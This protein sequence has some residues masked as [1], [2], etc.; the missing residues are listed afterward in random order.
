MDAISFV[1][2]VQTQQLR[3]AKLQDLVHL[4]EDEKGEETKRS[5]FVEIV[6]IDEEEH[7]STERYADR[8]NE[9]RFRRSIRADGTGSYSLN[10]KTVN[11]KRYQQI[12]K[13]IGI[14]VKARNFL[15]FQGDV[16]TI[17]Q[18]SPEELTK[19]FEEI[20][21]SNTLSE[22]YL[23]AEEACETVLNAGDD[24]MRTFTMKKSVNKEK[25][26]VQE[27][28]QEAERFQEMLDR[29]RES[30]SEFF[31]WQLFQ[32]QKEIEENKEKKGKVEADL[33]DVKEEWEGAQKAIKDHSKESATMRRKILGLEKSITKRK[34]ELDKAKPTRIKYSAQASGLKEGAKKAEKELRELERKGKAQDSK[35]T[36][37]KKQLKEIQ[38]EKKDFEAQS[39]SEENII[40]A[41]RMEE[42]NQK[43]QEVAMKT[44]QIQQDLDQ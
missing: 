17:A 29:L 13:K 12:L 38:R 26:M 42:Y 36:S 10:G 30:K 11:A 43:K 20:S 19:M 7:L 18:K 4:K 31:L 37:L 9:Y 22:E 16:A 14:L 6:F 44:A 3:G 23:K 24:L 27:Q 1:L 15:V 35:I 28:K 32:A 39:S 8:D 25:K 34:R 5:A 21:G 2:G 33:E 41:S 40:E